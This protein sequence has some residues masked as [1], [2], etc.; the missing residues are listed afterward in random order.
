MRKKKVVVLGGI[1]I[2]LIA[3]SIIDQYDDL[4]LIGFVNEFKINDNLYIKIKMSAIMGW[5]IYQNDKDAL[6]NISLGLS[7]RF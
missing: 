7:K 3:S 6:P 4:E 1:G 5:A 2:G